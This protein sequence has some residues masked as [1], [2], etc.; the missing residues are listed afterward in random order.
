MV[1]ND[2]ERRLGKITKH[3]P[4]ITTP[5]EVVNLYGRNKRSPRIIDEVNSLLEEKELIMEPDF[6]NAH[7]YAPVLVKFKMKEVVE[8]PIGNIVE[9]EELEESEDSKINDPIPRLSRLESANL[10]NPQTK[11]TKLLYVNREATIKEVITL[12]MQH[13][14]SQIPILNNTQRKAEGIVSW[15]SIGKAISLNK[16]PQRAYDCKEDVDLVK[17]DTPLLEVVDKVIK[18]EVVLVKDSEEIVCG[19]ITASDIAAAFQKQAEPFFLLEQIEKQIRFILCNCDIESIKLYLDMEK[20]E[21]TIN[22]IYDLT[23]GQ[24]LIALQNETFFNTL[25]ISI[26][27]SA[28]VNLLDSVRQIRNYVMHFSPDPLTSEDLRLLRNA[29]IFLSEINNN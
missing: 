1:K 12:M 6:G 13:N 27:R 7:C 21:K 25:G 23:F 2:L 5:T 16:N 28:F 19:I 29:A 22:D 3:K 10:R 9:S 4:W 24:Y 8:N 11:D 14:Y 17:L 15:K 18:K 20:C 26:D